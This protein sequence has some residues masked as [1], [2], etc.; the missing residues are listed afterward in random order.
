MSEKFLFDTSAVRGLGSEGF[1]EL[2]ELDEIKVDTSPYNFWEILCHLE[3]DFQCY[4]KHLVKFKYTNV[5]D[6]PEKTTLRSLYPEQSKEIPE[7]PTGTIIEKVVQKLKHSSSLREFYSKNIKDSHGVR[8]VSDCA[9]RVQ[10]KLHSMEEKFIKKSVGKILDALYSGGINESKEENYETF[11]R[12]IRDRP[13]EGETSTHGNKTQEVNNQVYLF[14]SYMLNLALKYYRNGNKV[15][16]MDRN[17]FEDATITL[18]LNID[19]DKTLV[20]SD[21][22][23]LDI[24]EKTKKILTQVELMPNFGIQSLESF[25]A[26]Y[27]V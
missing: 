14:T 13:E 1:K 27:G 24:V 18:H 9:Q 19:T 7:I 4:R 22:N 11:D 26:N 21:S 8:A 2:D 3:E 25:R 17:D 20:S 6:S 10:A 12:L 16:H 15:E 5:L 23:F